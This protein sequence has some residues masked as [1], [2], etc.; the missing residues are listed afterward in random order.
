MRRAGAGRCE[1]AILGVTHQ[2]GQGPQ[3]L[4]GDF[5]PP[6]AERARQQRAPGRFLQRRQQLGAAPAH[7]FDADIDPCVEAGTAG[8]HRA[9]R[10]ILGANRAR[11]S[12]P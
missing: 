10:R 4:R 8:I 12:Q 2:F 6:L 5:F 3:A 9:Q 7:P 11:Q 1:P